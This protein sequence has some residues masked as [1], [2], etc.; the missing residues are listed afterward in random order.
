MS[1]K[2][3]PQQTDQRRTIVV[4]I[5][6]HKDMAATPE[7][8]F[9]T[10]NDPALRPRWQRSLKRVELGEADPAGGVT[11]WREQT[12]LGPAFAMEIVEQDRPRR[13][14]ERGEGGGVTVSLLVGLAPSGT[15]SRMA[16][17]LTL[18]LPWPLRPAAPLLRLLIASELQGDLRRLDQL[19][20]E[21]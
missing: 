10:L 7:A 9:D 2:H 18:N 5:T 6:L 12:R 14:A 8:L 1:S 17:S 19:A 11:R 13:W 20:Q 15:G 21:R 16:L 4:D 3:V